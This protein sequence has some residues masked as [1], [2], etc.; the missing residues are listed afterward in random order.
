MPVQK[1]TGTCVHVRTYSCESYA[2]TQQSGTAECTQLYT[3]EHEDTCALSGSAADL[4]PA[5]CTDSCG[6][7]RT[8]PHC[9][10]SC[11][12]TPHTSHDATRH[13][14]G[15]WRC[16]CGGVHPQERET[17]RETLLCSSSSHSSVFV[18]STTPRVSR[19]RTHAARASPQ[20]SVVRNRRDASRRGH[21]QA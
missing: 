4:P 18:L 13:G 10:Q 20:V 16:E 3:S 6:A 11:P 21:D 15:Q 5:S 14:C 17:R 7:A 12:V 1:V 9:T 19:E 2:D 8:E